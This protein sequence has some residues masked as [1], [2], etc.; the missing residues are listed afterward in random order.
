MP[1]FK[2]FALGLFSLILC[3]LP[4]THLE[5][6]GLSTGFSEVMLENLELGK[7]YSTKEV[8]GLPLAVV[9][10][11]D[12]A[13]DLKIELLLPQ[14]SE[15][16]EG[17]EPIPDLSWVKLE[18]IEFKGVEPQD[19]ATTDVIISIPDDKKYQGKKYQVFIWSHTVGRMIGVGLKSKLLFTIKNIQ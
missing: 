15:L 4:Y 3:A 7:V 6:A 5:A 19:A 8:A 11:G 10:T 14:E 16:K 13:V 12:E 9:N 18:A 2:N 1:I 17:F